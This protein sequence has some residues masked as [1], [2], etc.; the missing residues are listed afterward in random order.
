MILYIWQYSFDLPNKSWSFDVVKVL[1]NATSVIWAQNFNTLGSF[2]IYVKASAELIDVF[3]GHVFITRDGRDGAMYVEK[4]ALNTD[5]EKGDYLIISGRTA[6]II[7]NWRVL[8]HNFINV[9][10][11]AETI[12]RNAINQFLWDQI[13]THTIY[14]GHLPFLQLGEVKGYT[15]SLTTQFTGKTLYEIV[16]SLCT[17]YNYGFKFTFDGHFFTFKLYKGTDRSFDQSENT[18]VVFSPDFENLGNTEY[19]EDYTKYANCAIIGGEGEGVDRKSAN[20]FP[21]GVYG[22]DFRQIYVDARSTSKK[23]GET[24]LT[25]AEY[26]E[27][28]RQKGIEA[29]AQHKIFVNYDGEILNT[30]SY[31]Y[32]VDY[33]LGDKVSVKNR[34]GITANATI[35]GITEVEDESGYRLVPTLSEWELYTY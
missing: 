12:M 19:T 13:P 35:T 33:E 3:S 27:I 5:D 30:N 22:M 16:N 8:F 7:L 24:K 9:E 6:E 15:D 23:S 2:E 18:Y 29:L 21:Q 4:V 32:G 31:I 11:T 28:L 17:E 34:Y 10:T 1:D 20:V 25:D 14:P 26:T